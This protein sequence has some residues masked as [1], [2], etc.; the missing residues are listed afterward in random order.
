MPI[1]TASAAADVLRMFEHHHLSL[2]RSVTGLCSLL[3]AGGLL[4]ACSSGPS[5]AGATMSPGQLAELALRNATA[6]RWVHETGSATGP[7]HV[8]TMVND[9]GTNEGRQVIDSN[10]ARST[11]LVINEVAYINGDAT[12]LTQYFGL[13]ISNPQEMAG[14]WISIRPTDQNYSAV[15]AA[16]T[17]QSDFGTLIS[18]PFTEGPPVVFDGR[19]LNALRGFVQGP[20]GAEN[21]P[22]T[23]YVTRTGTVLPVRLK[24]STG[25]VTETR[26]WSN[27]GRSVS[28]PI[29]SPSIPI[30][31][32]LG[33]GV[34]V[35]A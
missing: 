9:I 29:P 8:L 23:L 25:G 31:T 6:A 21:V 14:Q 4:T 32:V 24:A 22:A 34:G 11:V 5:N 1:K 16:V 30:S 27:W 33:T 28:L 2:H 17:L 12:A 20:S 18:G 10:G 13:Q 35:T 7:G 15:S 3:L 26:I 19:S